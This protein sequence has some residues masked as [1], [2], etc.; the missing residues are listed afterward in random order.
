VSGG[1]VRL[2][3]LGSFACVLFTASR[4]GLRLNLFEFRPAYGTDKDRLSFPAM[5]CTNAPP[6]LADRGYELYSRPFLV[7]ARFLILN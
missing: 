1:A 5:F 2:N 6:S 3:S 4:V 7:L